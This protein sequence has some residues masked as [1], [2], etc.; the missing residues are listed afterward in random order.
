MARERYTR[1]QVLEAIRNSGGV[2]LSVSSR[3]GCAWHT[4]DKYI[5]KWAE[6]RQ[7]MDAEG[8]SALDMAEAQLLAAVKR[9]EPW[10]IRM[11]LYTKGKKRGFTQRNELA[12]VQDAPLTLVYESVSPDDGD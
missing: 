9:A 1:E 5:N 10:A 7:A 3:L 12:G 8:E 6:T 11:L 2:I 4:A